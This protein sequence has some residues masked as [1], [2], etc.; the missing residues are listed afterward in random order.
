MTRPRSK[1]GSRD[2]KTKAPRQANKLPPTSDVKAPN[3]TDSL[4]WVRRI[5]CTQWND[6]KALGA[7]VHFHW[8]QLVESTQCFQPLPPN[9]FPSRLGGLKRRGIGG[10]EE[11][12]QGRGRLGLQLRF[13]QKRCQPGGHLLRLRRRQLSCPGALQVTTGLPFSS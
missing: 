1:I 13:Q 10:K 4:H 12:P 8:V 6:M 7:S 2:Q 5:A 3:G 9:A 11:I